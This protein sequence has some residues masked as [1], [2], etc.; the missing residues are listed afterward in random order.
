MPRALTRRSIPAEIAASLRER[1]LAGEF[2]AGAQ[3]R[4][5]A[6]A[7]DYGVSR[8]PVREALRRL[9][10]E[11]LV[12]IEPHKGAVVAGLAPAEILEL[13]EMRALLEAELARLAVPNLAAADLAEAETAL[14]LYE[15]ALAEGRVADW[16]SLNWRFHAALYRAAGRPLWLEAVQD[17]NRKTDRFIRLQLALTGALERAKAEHRGMLTLARAGLAEE[18]AALVRSHIRDASKALSAA[19][20]PDKTA[21]A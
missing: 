1:L 16:G 14:A 10:A 11:G 5:D 21:A 19:L 18:L 9:E 15:A 4:Q 3:L 6:L 13:F 12:A 7:A 20:E 8:I 17:L 2:A